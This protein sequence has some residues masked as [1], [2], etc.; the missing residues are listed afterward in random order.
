MA[1]EM[2]GVCLLM[3]VLNLILNK[4]LNVGS[5]HGP[6]D[7]LLSVR[8]SVRHTDSPPAPPNVAHVCTN[9]RPSVRPR[10]CCLSFRRNTQREDAR[11]LRTGLRKLRSRVK[12]RLH[13]PIRLEPWCLQRAVSDSMSYAPGEGTGSCTRIC[14]LRRSSAVC[15]LPSALKRESSVRCAT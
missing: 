15:S 7:R 10:V 6:T 13:T 12:V 3:G 9:V 5:V 4:N 1:A 8:P 14:A 11:T 2:T